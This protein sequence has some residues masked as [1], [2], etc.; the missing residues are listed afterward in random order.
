MNLYSSSV[1]LEPIVKTL[2]MCD[3]TCIYVQNKIIIYSKFFFHFTEGT[4]I[5]LH[6]FKATLNDT[7]HNEGVMVK[8]EQKQFIPEGLLSIS[9]KSNTWSDTIKSDSR[10]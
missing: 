6:I 9:S 10:F 3:I 1:I 8:T 2:S 5:F 7:S 4:N